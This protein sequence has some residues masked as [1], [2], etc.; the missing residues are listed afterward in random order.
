MTEL[1]GAKMG[2]EIRDGKLAKVGSTKRIQELNGML[3]AER[4]N[5]DIFRAKV[6]TKVY[7]ET[8]GQPQI[9]RRYKASAELYKSMK[10]VIYDHE[11]LAGWPASRIRG[12][13]IAIE[14]HAHWLADDL[15]NM[16]TRPYDPFQISEEDNNDRWFSP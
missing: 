13:Q 5:G 14:M 15:D 2:L 8:E 9:R 16:E 11:R 3:H 12:V 4:P 1:S 10:P 6:L 7:K